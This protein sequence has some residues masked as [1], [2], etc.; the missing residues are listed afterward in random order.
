MKHL[1]LIFMLLFVAADPAPRT[2]NQLT[3]QE[4]KEGWAL[5]FDGKSMS[6]WKIG[7]DEIPA[8]NIRDGTFNP[9]KM[10]GGR[11][12]YVAHY[13][14]KSFGDFVLSLDFKL[15]KECNSGV[16]FRMTD[17]TDPVQTGFEIQLFDSAAKAKVG[18][19][20]CGAL[21]DAR[22][23]SKNAAKPAGEWQHMEITAHG[24]SIVVVLNGER[25][26]D[27]DLNDWTEAGKNPDGTNNKFK[28]AYKQMARSGYIGLQDHLS[29]CWF[30]NLK[31]KPL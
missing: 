4:K 13:A 21:Y 28:T 1:P 20:D 29:D 23:P 8:D 17:P 6:G 26:L 10:G 22:E 18:K 15:T 5:L 2:D 19:H 7:D 27:V 12:L 24:S 16:F 3:E 11:K 30:R 14:A 31:I 25:V 9:F